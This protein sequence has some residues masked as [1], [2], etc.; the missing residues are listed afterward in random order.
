[1]EESFVEISGEEKVCAGA[2]A[3]RPRRYIVVASAAAAAV[4]LFAGGSFAFGKFAGS[5]SSPLLA[6][7]SSL[8][9]QAFSG[10]TA[11][12]EI[13]PLRGEGEIETVEYGGSVAL[14][15]TARR[16]NIAPVRS[17][18]LGTTPAACTA[19]GDP[20]HRVL[21]NEVAWAGAVERPAAE[22]IELFN[23]GSAAVP[24]AGWRL[25]NKSGGIR[26]AFGA[27]DAIA[28]EGFFLLERK[29][30]GAVPAVS[31]DA[32]FTNAIKNSDEELKLFDERCGLADKVETDAGSGKRWSAGEASPGY[33]SMERSPDLSW[34]TY[35]GAGTNGIFGTP[36]RENSVP[37]PTVATA[38]VATST[39]A[40]SSPSSS[41]A[42]SVSP[43]SGMGRVIISE[44]MAGMDGA[45]D[46]EFVELYNADDHAVDLTGWTLKKRSSTGSES[47]LVSASRFEGKTISAGRRFLLAND[48]GYTG[49][50]AAD[51]RWPKSYT[52]AY[53]NNAVVAYNAA[54]E[55]ID[56]V[57]WTE[58]PK[59]SGYARADGDGA[60]SVSA[61]P[62]PQN[63]GQ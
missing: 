54:G 44:V 18:S 48:G 53:A 38:V 19:S 42:V 3:P 47:T 39:S 36:K 50:V 6:N 41:P 23:P 37:V 60:F 21:I 10:S 25:S 9:S 59:G 43:V 13:I 63:S 16:E 5:G 29:D 49:A 1:M 20:S 55:K 52:F 4:F 40:S 56:E 15:N 35:I 17:G 45:S 57:S 11:A 34:H 22:W 30:D 12:V 27:N 46:Y 2:E 24:L 58:I 28:G 51:V 61:T 26:V 32:F 33:R 8:F 7:I 14:S 31:A 62:T